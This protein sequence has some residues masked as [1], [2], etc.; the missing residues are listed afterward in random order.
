MKVRIAFYWKLAIIL[1]RNQ[2]IKGCYFFVFF[3]DYFLWKPWHF[4]WTF[5]ICITTYCLSVITSA[6]HSCWSSK[7][8]KE[9]HFW[10]MDRYWIFSDR[11]WYSFQCLLFKKNL[12]KLSA[13]SNVF[14]LINY[15]NWISDKYLRKYNILSVTFFTYYIRWSH[16]KLYQKSNSI[17]AIFFMINYVWYLK[18]FCA[19]INVKRVIYLW[20]F[21][22]SQQLNIWMTINISPL[23]A[24]FYTANIYCSILLSFFYSKCV[25]DTRQLMILEFLRFIWL[26][27]NQFCSKCSRYCHIKPRLF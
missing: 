8:K 18:I 7:K 14:F 27:D 5:E 13:F 21:E 22:L 25:F 6:M 12:R 2:I 17:F 19:H 9:E 4:L 3:L 11:K 16:L 10:K 20:Y 24:Q 23:I 15:K 1:I 26:K